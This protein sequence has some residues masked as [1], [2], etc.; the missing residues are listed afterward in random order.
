MLWLLPAAAVKA[1]T[2]K[3]RNNYSA[4]NILALLQWEA[5]L[6]AVRIVNKSNVTV[7]SLSLLCRINFVFSEYILW[8]FAYG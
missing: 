8:Y 1:A 4:Q 2:D 6:P 5:K 7:N 3:Q